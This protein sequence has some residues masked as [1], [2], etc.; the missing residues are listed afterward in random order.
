MASYTD[1]AH[2]LQ[3]YSEF[4]PTPC[5]QAGLGLDDRQSWL[6]APVSQTRDSGPLDQS[7]F[8]AALAMLGGEGDTVEV[9]R[10][11]HWG[12]GWFEIVIVDPSDAD[13]VEILG[14][15]AAALADYPILDEMDYS[16][17]EEDEATE[18]WG[19]LSL[20][21]RIKLCSDN[22]ISI[23]AARHDWYPRDDCGAIRDALLGY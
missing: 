12:P 4:R 16:E 15:I 1:I 22:G 9:H 11:G 18:S 8:S 20:S 10:F 3:R 23:F 19:F 7:N 2:D 5:D 21:E 13:R 17:R 6:V 14:Q